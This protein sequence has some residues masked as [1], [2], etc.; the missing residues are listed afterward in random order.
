MGILVTKEI[1][2][3][4]MA[5]TLGRWIGIGITYLKGDHPKTMPAKFGLNKPSDFKDVIIQKRNVT[6]A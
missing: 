3:Y 6:T 2:I 4:L 1:Y 5:M